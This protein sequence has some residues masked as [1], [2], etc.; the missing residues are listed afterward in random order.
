MNKN[1]IRLRGHHLERLRVFYEDGNLEE[2]HPTEIDEGHSQKFCEGEIALFNMLIENPRQ[3]VKI[4][5]ELDNLCDYCNKDPRS[6]GCLSSELTL[7]DE[8]LALNY[9]LKVN[10]VYTVRTILKR[11]DEDKAASSL[12]P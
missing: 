8:E 9:E 5:A 7:S 12:K 10:R 11:F 4:C 2:Y 6:E 3:K 1:F